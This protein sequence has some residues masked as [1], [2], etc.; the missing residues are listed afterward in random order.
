VL[1]VELVSARHPIE[2]MKEQLTARW[3][4]LDPQSLTW[5]HE[6]NHWKITLI[7]DLSIP[8]LFYKIKKC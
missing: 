5:W 8:N 2:A 3:D 6:Y 7:M 4:M 1:L